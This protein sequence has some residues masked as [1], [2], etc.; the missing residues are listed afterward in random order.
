M[1]YEAGIANTCWRT[2]DLPFSLNGDG[3]IADRGILLPPLSEH[4]VRDCR[5]SKPEA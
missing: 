3:A 4:G 1:F 5:R 2:T